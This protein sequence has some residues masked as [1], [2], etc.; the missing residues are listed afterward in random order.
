MKFKIETFLN[1]KADY[2]TS[3]GLCSSPQYVY[4]NVEEYWLYYEEVISGVPT[5]R[6][7][8]MFPTEC[9]AK[10]FAKKFKK[11]FEKEEFQL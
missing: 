8:N 2:R 1:R 9:E 6:H 7:I 10:E 11:I 5:W 3:G 4:S